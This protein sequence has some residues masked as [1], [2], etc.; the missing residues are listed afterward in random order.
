MV[1][2]I[3]VMSEVGAGTRGASLGMDALRIASYHLD[4]TFFKTY[5]PIAVEAENSLLQKH[6]DT[7]Y[8]KRIKGVLRMYRRIEANVAAAVEDGKLPVV[9]TGDHS[10]GGGVI[11]GLKAALPKKRIGVIWIDAHADLHSP[12][13]SPSGNV[14]GM[15]LATALSEDN[16]DKQI[17]E[18]KRNTLEIWEKM[19]GAKPRIKPSDL[20]F[21]G[22]RDTEA[23]ED[24]LME[25]FS[26]P[27]F[28]VAQLRS[29]SPEAI[30]QKCLDHLKDCDKI[31]VSFDVDSMNPD[32]IGHGT[33]TPVEGGLTEE[34]ATRLLA[35]L[36]KS[37]KLCAMEMTEINPLLD[38]TGNT[39]GEVAF[40]ILKKT[41]A[42]IHKH[43]T[44][45]SK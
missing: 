6:V 17:N 5:K 23:P 21:V 15:P 40:R 43:H 39:V 24:Y 33:G 4:P 3:S 10:N 8:G 19:K 32:V 28:K 29:E 9:I 36:V 16:L 37:P 18:P 22:V 26:I 1:Q 38:K 14:H 12:Y 41:L 25:K 2:L 27:N 45:P 44:T 30:A 20:V 35:A 34:E 42:E 31:H 13:T 7:I 11:A